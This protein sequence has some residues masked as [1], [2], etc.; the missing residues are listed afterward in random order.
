M[1]FQITGKDKEE[2]A[3]RVE[4]HKKR[5]WEVYKVNEVDAGMY[6]PLQPDQLSRRRMKYPG[7]RP[8]EGGVKYIVVMTKKK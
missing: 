3:Q 6:P 2:V 5:G 7:I 4:D 8:R 1:R